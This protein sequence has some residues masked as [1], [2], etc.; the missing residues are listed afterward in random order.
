MRGKLVLGLCTGLL[1][2]AVLV[3]AC[4]S[5]SK[6]STSKAASTAESG[7]GSLQNS[8]ATAVGGGSNSVVGGLSTAVS[9]NVPAPVSTIASGLGLGDL[10]NLLG[11]SNTTLKVRTTSAGKVLTDTKGMT[12]YTSNR[13]TAGS[14]KSGVTGGVLQAWPAYILASGNPS[15]GDGVSGDASLITRDDGSKQV[16]YK[17]L[18]LYYWQNDKQPGDTTGNNVGGFTVAMP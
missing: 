6:S 16:A 9:G 10:N 4:S 18:P 7:I 8:V 12:L 13:D 5:G 1:A 2:V 3:T 17:G 11:D 15:K 14:G